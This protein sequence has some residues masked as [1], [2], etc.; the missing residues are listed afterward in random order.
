MEVWKPLK[1]KR[2]PRRLHQSMTGNPFRI[3]DEME[4]QMPRPMPNTPSQAPSDESPRDFCLP[5]PRMNKALKTLL[6]CI[7]GMAQFPLGDVR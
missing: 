1:P 4:M 5:Y 2:A 6:E 7:D 3:D